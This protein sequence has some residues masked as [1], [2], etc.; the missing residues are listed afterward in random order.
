MGFPGRF[1]PH[2][3]KIATAAGSGLSTWLDEIVNATRDAGID[4]VRESSGSSIDPEF[5]TVMSA[6]P[7][8]NIDTFDLSFLDTCGIDGLFILP[9][10]SKA[11]VTLYGRWQANGQLPDA[12][13]NTTHL[14][15]LVSDGL[16]VPTSCRASQG[17]AAHLSLMLHA[18]LGSVATYSQDT[19]MVA[20][21]DSA[22]A[23]GSSPLSMLYT[24]GPVAL[25]GDLLFGI[26]DAAV[27]FGIAVN[28]EGDNGEVYPTEVT[29]G[30]RMPTFEF[31]T[32]DAALAAA[33]G[34]CLEVT[35]FTQFFKKK[36]ANGLDED[37][38]DE[39]HIAISG[40]SG[41]IKPGSQTFAY[42][43]AS[44]NTF[45]YYPVVD[46]GAALSISVGSA[47]G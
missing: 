30:R 41:I 35:D 34:D 16:F 43:Q 2:S 39:V 22:I 23:S 8:I 28:V 29:I 17:Q 19:P 3:I 33:I 25:N 26:E 11:G 45:T 9:S 12:I 46:A 21:E 10:S 7:S 40:T 1:L 42:A 47:I 18:I 24:L 6:K 15:I 27:N 4:C 36:A 31:T 37:L 14:K 5:A 44:K 38:D 13:A 20:T 32:K